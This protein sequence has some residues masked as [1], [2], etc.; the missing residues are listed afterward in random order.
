MVAAMQH[1]TINTMGKVTTP[2]AGSSVIT[3]LLRPHG[4]S[5]RRGEGT[6]GDI[7]DKPVSSRSK[8]TVEKVSSI[9]ITT[10]DQGHV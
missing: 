7:L 3:R 10:L 1:A 9:S 5:C 6:E 8:F 2:R 4:C